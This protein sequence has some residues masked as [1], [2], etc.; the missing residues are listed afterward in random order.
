MQTP[1]FGDLGHG[2]SVGRM[3]EERPIGSFDGHSRATKAMKKLP[4][5]RLLEA[6][7]RLAG[8]EL[9]AAVVALLDVSDAL[10]TGW[11]RQRSGVKLAIMDAEEDL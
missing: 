6:A 7:T 10:L 3:K 2:R 9:N 5:L 11:R 4:L 1:D 8:P